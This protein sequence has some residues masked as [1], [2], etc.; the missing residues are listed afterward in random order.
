[1]SHFLFVAGIGE[2][3]LQGNMLVNCVGWLRWRFLHE[4][5][6]GAAVRI[7]KRRLTVRYRYPVHGLPESG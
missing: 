4:N 6:L 3:Y 5:G 2:E 1:M 7:H